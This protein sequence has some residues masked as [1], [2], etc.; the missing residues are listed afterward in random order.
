[1][2]LSLIH[3]AALVA[4]SAVAAGCG[5]DS[6]EVSETPATANAAGVSMELREGW[7]QADETLT[8]NLISPEEILSVGTFRMEPGGG[9]NHMPQHAYEAMSAGDALIT[10]M[11]R[12]G[13]AGGDQAYPPRPEHFRFDSIRF[14]CLPDNLIGSR[15]AFSES[16]RKFYAWVAVGREASRDEA[17]A[18]L[19]S[20]RVRPDDSADDP[21]APG[22]VD[23]VADGCKAI[24][25]LRQRQVLL[26]CGEFSRGRELQI[27]T[28]RDSGG[29]S[30]C[31][32]IYGVGGHMSRACGYVPY[33]RDPVPSSPITLD[34]IYRPT[35]E[36]PFE[37]Y[38]SASPGVS[39]VTISYSDGNGQ[40]DRIHATLLQVDD[41][42]ALRAARL[43][44]P[45]R[46]FVA[47]VPRSAVEASAAATLA[48]SESMKIN[49]PLRAYS[50]PF[51]YAR[52]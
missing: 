14:E 7:R 26:A 21:S 52:E 5:D 11:E 27:R 15:H 33:K 40:S 41:E 8:P 28:E 48:G 39:A 4:L 9:C 13:Q 35:Q 43:A 17:M 31:L 1:V 49:L 25:N 16:G 45:F 34:A 29:R 44:R 30:G 23:W 3:I 38:G 32:E 24:P 12:P 50:P 37:I 20:F 36:A 46:Y 51:V 19:N 18:V 42:A 2:C 47:E 10:I 6:N 22:G